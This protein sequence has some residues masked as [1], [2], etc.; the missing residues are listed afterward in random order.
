[1]ANDPD[2]VRVDD[3]DRAHEIES[4]LGSLK[5]IVSITMGPALSNTIVVLITRG[6]YTSIDR[7]SH[8]GSWAVVSAAAVIAAIIRFYHGNNRFMDANYAPWRSLERRGRTRAP[9]G[10][11][12]LQLL[13]RAHSVRSSTVAICMTVS[14]LVRADPSLDVDASELERPRPVRT[15]DLRHRRRWFQCGEDDVDD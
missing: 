6:S 15:P 13:K 5:G 1:M 9:R 2:T 11:L 3:Q 4:I 7:L 8:L 14:P 10:G 12:G